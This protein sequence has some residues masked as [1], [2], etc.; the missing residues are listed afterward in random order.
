MLGVCLLVW[1]S[2]SDGHSVIQVVVVAVV[3]VVVGSSYSYTKILYG[4]TAYNLMHLR[5]YTM[6]AKCLASYLFMVFLL[7]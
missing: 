2:L 6:F 3:V 7:V 1:Q 4:L 5:Y